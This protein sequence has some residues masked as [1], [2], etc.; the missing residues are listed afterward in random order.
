M[1][2]NGTTTNRRTDRE[3]LNGSPIEV[4]F[5]GTTYVWLQRS[6]REQADMRDKLGEILCLI[7]VVD[8]Q[9]TVQAGMNA[10]KAVNAIL[11]FC[12]ENNDEMNRDIDDIEDYIKA[13]GASAFSEII[14][15][16]YMVLYKEW[17][18]PWL[19][20][21]SSDTKKKKPAS[22]QNRKSTKR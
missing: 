18:E 4:T 10:L 20:G 16:V 22:T 12:E 19:V 7:S 11:L 17:L 9:G 2:A 14:Q 13:E 8:G 6:R 3:I 21:S 1:S 15:D 5:N